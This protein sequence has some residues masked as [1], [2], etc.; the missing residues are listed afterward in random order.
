MAG[1]GRTVKLLIVA[2]I[3]FG[4]FAAIGYYAVKSS[5]YMTVSQVLRL[6]HE[7][8]VT[9][10]GYLANLQTDMRNGKLYLLLEDPKTG[11]KLIAVAD[12]KFIEDRYGP[13][14]YLQW[15]PD[16]IVVEGIYN[17]ATKTLTITNVLQG[18]HSSYSQQPAR[19]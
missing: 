10:R 14:Q 6:N 2:A 17:P 16:N 11:D 18:C 1:G 3:L 8:R 5:G 7:A 13:I 19:T 9:V 12:V 15:D 4:A